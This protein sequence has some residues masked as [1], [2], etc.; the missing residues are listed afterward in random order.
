MT[1]QFSFKQLFSVVDGRMSTNI[2]DIY[3]ILNHVTGESLMTHHLPVALDYLKSKT[4]LWLQDCTKRLDA[5]KSEHG[6]DFLTLMG[7]IDNLA[8]PDIDVP[9]IADEHSADD[10]GSF[11]VDNSILLWR[12]SA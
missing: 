9:Q 7:V 12:A 6:N 8:L 1:K 2:D 11:M 3:D 10:F 4:P 5:M